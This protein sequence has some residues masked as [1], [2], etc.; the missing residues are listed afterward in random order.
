MKLLRYNI[1]SISFRH[2]LVS[3]RDLVRFA[4]QT[5]FSGIELWGVHAKSMLETN[6]LEVTRMVTEMHQHHIGVSM[7]SDYV[8]LLGVPDKFAETES[9]WHTLIRLARLFQ[10]DKIRIFAANKSSKSASAEELELCILR[11]KR[12]ASLSSNYGIYTLVE[13]H[14]ETFADTLDSTLHLA[15]QVEHPFLRI[16]LDFLHMWEAHC[17]PLEAYEKLM[18][19]TSNFHLKNV[20]GRHLL[21]VFKPENVYSPS[22]RTDGM[23]MLADGVVDYKPIIAALKQSKTQHSI[24]LEWFGKDPFNC[25]KKELIWLKTQ[26]L[27]VNQA[28]L[29]S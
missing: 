28:N 3:F 4:H 5:G 7:I 12:L 21:E 8:D 25:L 16:N 1:C 19:W 17:D 29:Y 27:E 15:Q 14:P 13:T 6:P 26:E 9:K 23:V 10:T 11:L 24:S 2:G 22:G 20:R 18:P